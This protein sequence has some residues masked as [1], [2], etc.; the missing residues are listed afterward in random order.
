MRIKFRIVER[1]FPRHARD[2]T[3]Y[4]IANVVVVE[5]D[6]QELVGR[7]MTWKGKLPAC[8]PY[9]LYACESGVYE[10]EPGVSLTCGKSTTVCCETPSVMPTDGLVFMIEQELGQRASATAE[11]VL[12][13]RIVTQMLRGK[14]SA[15][16]L[17]AARTGCEA[18]IEGVPCM[19]DVVSNDTLYYRAGMLQD[20]RKIYG[21]GTQKIQKTLRYDLLLR[22]WHDLGFPLNG[23]S[24]SAGAPIESLFPLLSRNNPYKMKPLTY[25]Q[26]I[27]CPA[28]TGVTP[29][30]TL[31]VRILD[32]Y[33]KLGQHTG[34][35]FDYLHKRFTQDHPVDRGSYERSFWWLVNT[36]KA[37]VW[38]RDAAMV[39]ETHT[40]RR[41]TEIVNLLSALFERFDPEKSESL[42]RPVDTPVPCIPPPHLTDEQTLAC[43]HMLNN[44]F[45]MVCG[46]PGRGKT[47]ILEVKNP[48]PLRGCGFF[49]DSLVSLMFILRLP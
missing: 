23:G 15:R 28:S 4:C 44:P 41:A 32:C 22:L 45:T 27:K 13:S 33:R 36:V 9:V 6:K 49:R 43:L 37:L 18:L 19:F 29:F 7:T 48:Q 40:H 46:P 16:P 38:V 5:C 8:V 25:G 21:E 24:G 39:S 26:F 12:C 34:H 14:L 10:D 20:V 11:D 31:G 17:V 2:F 47:T 30:Q 3:D 42:L 35:A 1:K